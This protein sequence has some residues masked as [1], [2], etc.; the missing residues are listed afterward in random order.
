MMKL[1]STIMA[2]FFGFALHGTASA[3]IYESKDAEGV[4]E[5]S[6]TPTSGAEIVD[7]PPT[8]VV[9]PVAEPAAAPAAEQESMP[10]NRGDS[11]QVVGEAAGGG[12]GE[13]GEPD[14]L[15]DGYDGYDGYG[16]EGPRE[17]RREDAARIDNRLP[18][19]VSGAVGNKA[20][21]DAAVMRPDNAEQVLHPETGGEF[22][23]RP[24]GGERR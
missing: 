3:Q 20:A 9:T 8:N 10:A 21:Q 12:G 19:E 7:L 13:D 18:G 4:T 2:C 6:D 1:P 14:Y 17:Q 16:E 15:Y 5:F 22:Q 11:G 23:G 24:G